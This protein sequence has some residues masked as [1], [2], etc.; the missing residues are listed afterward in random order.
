VFSST[1]TLIRWKHGIRIDLAIEAGQERCCRRLGV[2][3]SLGM[4][5]VSS[6]SRSE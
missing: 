2:G 1:G 5:G 4:E 6:D 3:P